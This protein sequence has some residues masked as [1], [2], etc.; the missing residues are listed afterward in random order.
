MHSHNNVINKI[1]KN[2]FINYLHV[3]IF[4]SFPTNRVSPSQLTTYSIFPRIFSN[5]R[6]QCIL[7]TRHFCTLRD[8]APLNMYVWGGFSKIL[9]YAES[10]SFNLC[11][12][13]QKVIS[14]LCKWQYTLSVA[15]EIWLAGYLKEHKTNQQIMHSLYW[16]SL[17]E[18]IKAYRAAYKQCHLIRI[19][20]Y[21]DSTNM[22]FS[23]TWR[24]I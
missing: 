6:L 16:L 17:K 10:R 5:P 18:D 22:F 3:L 19:E 21:I 15:L 12:R 1:I 9:S 24:L 11:I 8:K 4:S 7:Y 23:T 14:P 2:I 13:T 20:T